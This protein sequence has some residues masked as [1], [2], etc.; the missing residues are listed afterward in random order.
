MPGYVVPAPSVPEIIHSA[1]VGD[2]IPLIIEAQ[3]YDLYEYTIP[4]NN[5]EKIIIHMDVF[6]TGK[7]T[8]VGLVE[9]NSS[10]KI[11]DAL[12]ATRALRHHL[13]SD[14]LMRVTLSTTHAFVAKSGAI[15]K[16]Q[17]LKANL[18]DAIGRL[19]SL[20]IEGYY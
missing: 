15:V 14:Q 8:T 10:V 7:C 6:L 5:Y 13:L 1:P 3:C 16:P 4:P 11:N 9:V 20:V 2:N 18:Y 17:G 19:E 12:W